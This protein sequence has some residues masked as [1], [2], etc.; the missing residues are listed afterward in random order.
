MT[1]EELKELI[2]RLAEKYDITLH[3]EGIRLW[4]TREPSV[5]NQRIASLDIHGRDLA[6][7][8]LTECWWS[9]KA[10]V[11]S[12]TIGDIDPDIAVDE[13]EFMLKCARFAKE[14]NRAVQ[15]VEVDRQPLK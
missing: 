12:N 2:E 15:G 11:R 4:T 1:L 14:F 10:V 8:Q 3:N 5:W 6:N 13:A 7:R 9:Y